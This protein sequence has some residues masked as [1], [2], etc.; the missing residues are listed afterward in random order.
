MASLT[1]G[2]W[3]FTADM[4]RSLRWQKWCVVARDYEK[5]LHHR[6]ICSEEDQEVFLCGERYKFVLT[7]NSQLKHYVTWL[8]LLSCQC[9]SSSVFWKQEP[10]N[11]WDGLYSF[12][13]AFFQTVILRIF[14]SS[15]KTHLDYRE[16]SQLWYMILRFVPKD[17]APSTSGLGWERLNFA[18]HLKHW[19]SLKVS[20]PSGKLSSLINI[21]GWKSKRIAMIIVACSVRPRRHSMTVTSP[22]F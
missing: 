9:W 10:W 22:Q 5:R 12:P 6:R 20:N 4:S 11:K 7:M 14:V 1:C 8:I 19:G 2:L 16:L 15:G 21:P 18:V 3:G 13:V 17:S